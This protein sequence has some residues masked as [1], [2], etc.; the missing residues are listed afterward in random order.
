MQM[1]PTYFGQKPFSCLQKV[2]AHPFIKPYHHQTCQSQ[3]TLNK[4]KGLFTK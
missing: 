4:Q 3:E 2:K 1:M